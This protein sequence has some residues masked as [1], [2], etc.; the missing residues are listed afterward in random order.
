MYYPQYR[1]LLLWRYFSNFNAKKYAQQFHT[2]EQARL[3]IEEYHFKFVEKPK[4]IT[5]FKY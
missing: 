5:E 3:F 2:E 4:I 1:K